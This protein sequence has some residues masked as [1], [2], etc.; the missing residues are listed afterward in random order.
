MFNIEEITLMS[1]YRTDSRSNLLEDLKKVKP[2]IEDEEILKMTNNV[3]NKLETMSDAEYKKI[4]FSLAIEQ[5]E[6]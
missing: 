6:E 5:M 2:H 3:I 4:D 1:L